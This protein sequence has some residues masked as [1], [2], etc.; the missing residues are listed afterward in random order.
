MKPSLVWLNAIDRLIAGSWWWQRRRAN[1][2]KRI[3][4]SPEDSLESAL[5][6]AT[7]K[8]FDFACRFGRPI[9]PEIAEG[10]KQAAINI[11]DE[12]A[13]ALL[14]INKDVS[15]DDGKLN[16][17]QGKFFTALSWSARVLCA[18]SSIFLSAL[19]AFAPISIAP[20]LLAFLV[21]FSVLIACAY[22]WEL[23]TS[24]PLK[25]AKYLASQPIL[26]EESHANDN[27]I[28]LSAHP[29]FG[30]STGNKSSL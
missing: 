28:S 2:E 7:W 1:A 13:L 9:N 10:V 24:R 5:A 22:I 23:Y 8:K 20:K 3:T 26:V 25:A 6:Y 14:V 15:L 27:V 21:T 18:V 12:H 16:Y 30:S 29:S 19:L 11:N 4:N 17:R